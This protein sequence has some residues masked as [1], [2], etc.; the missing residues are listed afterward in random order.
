MTYE[1]ES[2]LIKYGAKNMLDDYKASLR[3]KE[4]NKSKKKSKKSG[5]YSKVMSDDV[6]YCNYSNRVICDDND[7]DKQ[8]AYSNIQVTHRY[9]PLSTPLPPSPAAAP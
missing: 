2:N 3:L 4:K 5:Y 9:P 8:Q 7:S 6:Y 1:P